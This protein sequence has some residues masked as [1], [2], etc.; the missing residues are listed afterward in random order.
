M[1]FNSKCLAHLNALSVFLFSSKTYI[2]IQSE[3]EIAEGWL[4][5]IGATSWEEGGK[6]STMA[7]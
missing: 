1:Y 5:G 3:G 2:Y 4:D 7:P 6:R